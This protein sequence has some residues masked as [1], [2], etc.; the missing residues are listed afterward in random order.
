MEYSIKMY[1]DHCCGGGHCGP[2]PGYEFNCP[3]C[4]EETLCRTGYPLKVEQRFKC[5]KCKGS[6]KVLEIDAPTFK[7]ETVES[8]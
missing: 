7:V 6:L 2:L 5:I 8:A 3:L 1:E 4:N